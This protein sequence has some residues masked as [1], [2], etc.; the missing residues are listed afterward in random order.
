MLIFCAIFG[1][2]LVADRVAPDKA[3]MPNAFCGFFNGQITKAVFH[4]KNGKE[5]RT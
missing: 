3:S 5:V 2:I 4:G 1:I